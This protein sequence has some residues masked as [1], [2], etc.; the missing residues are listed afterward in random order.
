MMQVNC[1]HCKKLLEF[2]HEAAGSLVK[3]PK[4]RHS[5]RLPDARTA[6]ADAA[7]SSDDSGDHDGEPTSVFKTVLQSIFLITTLSAF[8]LGSIIGIILLIKLYK[9]PQPVR[10]V[11]A[12]IGGSVS[13]FGGSVS[14]FVSSISGLLLAILILV[15]VIGYFVFV[16]SMAAWVAR[17]AHNRSHTGLG[18]AVFYLAWQFA[19]GFTALPLIPLLGIGLLILPFGWIGLFIYLGG[20]R[21]GVFV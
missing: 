13:D 6:P 3:C 2:G 14:D 7:R 8:I 16:I 17:D 9:N 11:F 10:E 21:Q 4:C 19:A 20:R 12:R 15:I 1:P 18:W 5:L